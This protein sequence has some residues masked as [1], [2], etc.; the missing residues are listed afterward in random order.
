MD[1]QIVIQGVQF[2]LRSESG[3]DIRAAARLVNLRWEEVASR[4]RPAD[5]P[6]DYK[7]TVTMLTALN[8]ASELYTLRKQM[9]EKLEELDRDAA[10]VAAR[11]E[12]T[13]PRSD[14]GDPT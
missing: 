14:D 1:I 4:T 2:N 5:H 10:A 8:L 12:A 7:Y 3:E 9:T 13:L 11:L 6:Q